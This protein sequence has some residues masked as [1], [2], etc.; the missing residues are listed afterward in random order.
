[1]VKYFVFSEKTII[2]GKLCI[3]YGIRAV[4]NSNCNNE[5]VVEISN[6]TLKREEANILCNR[7]NKHK[8]SPVHLKDV[9]E[10]FLCEV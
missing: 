5:I 4:D 9:C 6:V 3:A 8:L 1:M 10:D 2:D 7:C